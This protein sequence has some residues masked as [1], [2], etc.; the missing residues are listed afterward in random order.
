[1]ETHTNSFF[2]QRDDGSETMKNESLFVFL[3]ILL[4]G[5]VCDPKSQ[6][7]LMNCM[8]RRTQLFFSF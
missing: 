3:Q 1:M 5:D 4:G 7:E 6:N 2:L 8:C